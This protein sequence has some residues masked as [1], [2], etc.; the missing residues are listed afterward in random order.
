VILGKW[1]YLKTSSVVFGN[2]MWTT[3]VLLGPNHWPTVSADHGFVPA[4]E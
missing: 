3:F 4:A 2:A 1:I